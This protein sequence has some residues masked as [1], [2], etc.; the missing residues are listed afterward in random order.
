MTLLPGF[1]GDVIFFFFFSGDA[2]LLSASLFLSLIIE[3]SVEIDNIDSTMQT[4]DLDEGSVSGVSLSHP[5][6]PFT[7][8][9]TERRTLLGAD[10]PPS[11]K[12][13]TYLLLHN[14]RHAPFTHCLVVKDRT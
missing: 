14:L 3:M 10:L 13:M 11:R 8:Q 6:T 12:Y 7:Q 1:S 5:S 2:G 4:V 9:D